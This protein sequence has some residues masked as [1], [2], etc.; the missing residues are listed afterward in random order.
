VD[1]SAFFRDMLAP[2]IKAS[3]CQ[4]V[5]VGSGAEALQVLKSE[6]RFDVVVT[7]VEMPEMD[8]FALAEALHAMPATAHLPVIAISAMV[9]VDTVERGRAIGFHDFV[10]KFDRTG[11]ITAIKEQS[12]DIDRA[13]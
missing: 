12:A 6:R 2:L 9:S 5:A 10:A 3:G 8:G 4:V 1:D 13:A 7:D 11:L